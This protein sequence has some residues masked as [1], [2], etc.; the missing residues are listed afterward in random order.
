MAPPPPDVATDLE[1]AA[2]SFACCRVPI[3]LFLVCADTCFF[4]VFDVDF[5]LADAEAD[6]GEDMA[7]AEESG[8]EAEAGVESG[9]RLWAAAALALPQCDRPRLL[10]IA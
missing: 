7:E 4:E 1:A 8:A 3:A 9:R 6:A 5:D 10:S 2:A